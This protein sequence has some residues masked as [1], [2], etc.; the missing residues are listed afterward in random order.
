MPEIYADFKTR[1]ESLRRTLSP[2]LRINFE[3][4]VRMLE[5][6]TVQRALSLI[7][8]FEAVSRVAARKETKRCLKSKPSV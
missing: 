3:A 5:R 7:E 6:E 4:R 8:E 2:R 1:L